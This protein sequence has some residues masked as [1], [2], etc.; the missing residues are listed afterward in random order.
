MAAAFVSVVVTLIAAVPRALIAQAKIPDKSTQNDSPPIASDEL[1]S[2]L[3]QFNRGAALLEQYRYSDAAE[4]LEHVVRLFPQWTAAEFNLSLAYLRTGVT[5]AGVEQTESKL[6]KARESFE[7][8]VAADPKNLHARFCLGLYYEYVAQD[9]KA[10]ECF[11]K[12]LQT[13]EKNADVAS[14]CGEILIRLGRKEEAVRIFEKAID[15]DPGSTAAYYHLARL[16]RELGRVDQA[17]ASLDRFKKLQ[18]T[19]FFGGVWSRRGAHISSTRYDTPLDAASL[20]RSANE[21]P[22]AA[23][24]LLSPDVHQLDVRLQ[25]WKWAGGTVG[26]PGI[27]VGDLN[28]DGHLDLVLTAAGEDGETSTW[29]NDGTG[30]FSRSARVT[31]KGV[32]PCLGDVNNDGHLDL[33]LGRARQDLLFLNDGKGNLRPAPSPAAVNVGVLTACAR[34]ID[35]DSDG[36]L[37]LMSLRW[38]GGSIPA[39]GALLPV[40]SSLFATVRSSPEPS[41]EPPGDQARETLT[42]LAPR[43]GLTFPKT[44]MSAVIYDDFDNDLDLDLIFFPAT[45]SPLVWVND[46][47][48]AYRILESTATGLP[49][50][51][52]ISATS[53]D[54][55]RDGNRDLLIFTEREVQRFRN[56]GGFK[57]ELDEEFA[58]R[59]GPLGGTG[60]QFADLDNDGDLDLVIADAHRRDASRGPVV[61]LNEWPNRRFVAATDV[62]PGNLLSAVRTNGST[63]CVAADFNGDGRLDILLAE[64]NEPPKWIEN[65]TPGGHFIAL[66]LL[67]KQDDMARSNGSSIGARVELRSGTV[68]Q[69]YVVGIPSGPTAMPPLRIHAGLGPHPQVQWLRIL[70]PDSVLQAELEV[71]ADQVRQ[72][73]QHNRLM[74]TCP[75][76]FAWDGSRFALVSDFG[77]VGGLGYWLAPGVYGMPRPLEYVPIRRFEPRDGQY[78]LQILESLEETVYVDE[79]KLIAVDHPENTEVSPHELMAIGIPL[80]PFEIFCFRDAIEPVGAVDHRGIDVTDEIRRIDRCYAGATDLHEGL[81]GYAHDHRVELDFSERLRGLSPAARPI[82]VLYG[83]TEYPYSSTNYAASLEGLRMKP[84]S[85]H[86]WRDGRWVE[87]L[88]EVGCPAGMQHIMT[89]DLTGKILPSDRKLSI[90]SNMEIYWDRIFVGVHLADVPLQLQEIAAQSADLHFRGYAQRYSPDGR[91]PE[92]YDYD[93]VDRAF[94]WKLMQGEYTRYGQVR[95]LLDQTDDCYVIMARGDELTLRFSG[96]AFG[97]VR[98]GYRRSFILKVD[99]YSKDMN[100]YTPH[101]STVEPLPF[102]AMR[103]YPYG[104]DQGYPET[105]KTNRYRRSFNTRRVK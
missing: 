103:S 98:P 55:Y 89:V 8:L 66:D 44:P 97:P 77:G 42:D 88:H 74:S 41:A 76:L 71:A 54:P 37:D 84:P 36:S 61:L 75:H 69:Q 99:S 58:S 62:D 53:G 105:E 13:D 63:S 82:L 11:E 47:V 51:G 18:T 80:P 92:L 10:L 30:D 32:S 52:V 86:A 73:A 2:A 64:M 48:G 46:R 34:L 39:G 4:A 16:Y 40:A 68:S 29:L 22:A 25:P 33:W 70:W 7:K 59:C 17:K 28:G 72:I 93:R 78:V 100:L 83:T 6:E 60:G 57:F 21:P 49:V 85:I 27:A 87:V 91:R 67:G 15:L 35:G 101:S 26:L 23:R 56:R 95:E 43:L 9:E 12:V 31:D 96:D 104:P 3:S 14:R 90:S 65:V 19:E 50:Q 1:S 94:P 24:L 102:H 5:Q 45:G 20:P 81:Y 79:T 38:A